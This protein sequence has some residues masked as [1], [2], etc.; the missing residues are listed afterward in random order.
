MPI[1][2]TRK[3]SE[4]GKLTLPKE[5]RELQGIKEG[6][7]VRVQILEVIRRAPDG[8]AADAGGAA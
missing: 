7:F 5:V 2:F 6:D 3:V 8:D 4:N 1:E